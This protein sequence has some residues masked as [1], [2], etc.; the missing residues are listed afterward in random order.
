MWLRALFVSK[1]VRITLLVLAVVQAIAFGVNNSRTNVPIMG[2]QVEGYT[3]GKATGD[4]RHRV[5]EVIRAWENNEIT[6]KAAGYTSAVNLRQLGVQLDREQVYQ[7]VLQAG[8]GSNLLGRLWS[9]NRALIGEL[10]IGLRHT[11]FN[12]QLAENYLAPLDEKIAAEP[13][14]ARFILRQQTQEEAVVTIEPDTEGTAIDTEASI[15]T[16][17]QAN[18]LRQKQIVLLIRHDKAQLTT[19]HLEPILPEVRQIAAKPLK[20]TAA[21]SHIELSR[22]QLLGLIVPKLA[23]DTYEPTAQITFDKQKLKSYVD[24][25]VSQAAY[26]PK[27]TIVVG[28]Q[29]VQQGTKGL[30]IND[31][32]PINKVMEALQQRQ[33]D[34]DSSGEV[35]LAMV[36]IEPPVVHQAP[37]PQLRTG[38]GLVRLTFDDGPG[39]YTDHILDILRRYNVKATFYVLGNRVHAYAGQMQRKKNEGHTIA[40]H[41]F[42]HA[43][44]AR[45]SRAAVHRELADTQTV[46]QQTTGV[47]ARGFRPPYGATNQT[48][49][50]VAASLGLSIDMWSVDPKDWAQP[51]SGV[52]TRRVLEALHPGAVVVLHVNNPQTVQALPGMIEGIRRLG[53]TLE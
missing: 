8:R 45:L 24:G 36:V 7:E 6:V 52:I 37:P 41:S 43:N 29:V 21:Q 3:V 47:T 4:F 17:S 10:G 30:G 53:Y 22:E 2:L 11:N 9:Q 23:T 20:I 28:G 39:Y 26:A 5:N 16:L 33:K 48:V 38:T 18:P 15:H 1:S 31:R 35:K 27:P 14:D 12:N 49:R 50:E 51:G 19:G 34:P 32:Q 42:T 44:L 40:N 13:T 46:I 25:V